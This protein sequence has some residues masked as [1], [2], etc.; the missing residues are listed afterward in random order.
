MGNMKLFIV[1][2]LCAIAAAAPPRP[3]QV[4]AQGR[5]G[6]R[7]RRRADGEDQQGGRPDEGLQQEGPGQGAKGR[8]RYRGPRQEGGKDRRRSRGSI[9]SEN[10][11]LTA[12]HCADGA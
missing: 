9:I 4:Q 3:E 5:Y 12:A 7:Q 2:A 8:L 10:Y 6:G 11:V 1:A